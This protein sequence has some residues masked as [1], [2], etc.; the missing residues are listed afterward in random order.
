MSFSPLLDPAAGHGVIDPG[1]PPP[2]VLPPAA[3][4]LF[5]ERAAERMRAGQHLPTGAAQQILE[6][7]GN[8]VGTIVR[9]HGG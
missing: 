8:I 6:L 1:T 3:Q 4:S 9:L 5:G 7:S 2:N